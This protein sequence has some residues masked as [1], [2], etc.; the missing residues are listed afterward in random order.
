M[1]FHALVLLALLLATGRS[2]DLEFPSG[3]RA[4]LVAAVSDDGGRTWP[5]RKLIETE[6]QG[7]YCYTAIHFT[8]DAM[9]LAYCAGDDKV[10]R[11][12]RLR[13][14]RIELSWLP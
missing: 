8:R 9:L 1:K 11:L 3:R 5:R 10:G 12:A 13:I 14:R 2:A 7:W 6:L 4:P